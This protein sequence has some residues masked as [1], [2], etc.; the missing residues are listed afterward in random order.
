[1]I[2]ISFCVYRFIKFV[3]LQNMPAF[4]YANLQYA[5]FVRDRQRWPDGLEII[6]V[7]QTQED[8][9][10]HEGKACLGMMLS[11][12]HFA[13]SVNNK[14]M[15]IQKNYSYTNSGTQRLRT[16]AGIKHD[17]YDRLITFADLV[18]GNGQCFIILCDTLTITNDLFNNAMKDFDG[19]GKLYLLEECQIIDRFLGNNYSLP[20]IKQV[21]RLIAIDQEY[22]TIC[23][24]HELIQPPT[25]QTMYF[26]QH[27]IDNLILL[28]IDLRPAICSGTLC[29]R[30]L[31]D[32][33]L[34]KKCGCFHMR[35]QNGLVIEM[36]VVIPTTKG[37]SMTGN[38]TIRKF[39][40][41]ST[42]KL[43]LN[44]MNGIRL[45]TLMI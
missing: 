43:F 26:C 24:P 35:Q 42:T 38:I 14:V 33:T 34:T 39:R 7:R 17:S 4:Q 32:L 12:K 23:H 19:V 11:I 30:Q 40:S 36:D 21:G 13:T 15:T 41:L 20:I 6:S 37:F 25:G 22:Q 5:N 9:Y 18:G 29:D 16:N 45:M 31:S 2:V 8:S 10:S 44:Q 28:N 1:M 3:D 27:E